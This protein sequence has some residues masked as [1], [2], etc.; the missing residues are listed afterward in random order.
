MK[1]TGA[2]GGSVTLNHRVLQSGGLTFEGKLI[3]E[4]K[5][6]KIEISEEIYKDRIF[7]DD[8]TGFIMIRDLQMS[9]SGPYFI[10]SPQNGGVFT[11]SH[12]L[13]VSS[14]RNSRSWFFLS[15]TPLF[16]FCGAAAVWI[17]WTSFKRGRKKRREREEEEERERDTVRAEFH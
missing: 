10:T 3:A 14:D 11:T 4:V 9:D 5:N 8:K 2:E 1:L 16:L 7:L 13:T 12:E 6:G 17:I 15:L